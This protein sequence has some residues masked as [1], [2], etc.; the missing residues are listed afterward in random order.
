MTT[1]QFIAW[2]DRKMVK[3]IGKLVPPD[4]VLTAELDQRIEQKVR[5]TLTE[6]ILREAGL[7][8]QV[9]DAVAKIEKP[10]AATLAKGI[11]Q[12]FK[13]QADREWRDHIETEA[14]K[15]TLKI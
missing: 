14:K 3:C 8:R 4:D 5:D 1:P 13:Q 2:L 9:T 10:S 6:R 7:E 15:R 12:S 11:K